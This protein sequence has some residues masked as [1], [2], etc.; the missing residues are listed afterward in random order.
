MGR[1][2]SRRRFWVMAAV[3]F[4]VLGSFASVMG[5]REAARNDVQASRQSLATTS[6]STAATLKLALLHEQDLV[7]ATGAF[8]VNS[9]GA[10]EGQFS[11]WMASVRALQ[12]YPELVGMAEVVIVPKSQLASFETKQTANHLGP[13]Q[14]TPA[15]SRPYYCFARVEI[16]RAGQMKEPAGLDFCDTPLGPLFLKAVDTGQG[17]ILPFRAGNTD[18]LAIG[19]PVYSS[20][21]A[22]ATPAARRADFLGWTGTEIV[23][24]VLLTSALRGHANTAV[25]FHYRSGSI[26]ASFEAGSA[27]RG[28]SSQSVNLHDGWNVKVYGTLSAGSIF[29]NAN[30]L[31]LLLGGIAVSLLIGALMYVLA[32]SRSRALVLVHQRTDELEHLALHDP[33]TG[34]PNRA[35]ILDR[36]TQMNARARRDRSAVALFYLDL[37]DFKDINDSLGHQLGDRLLIEVGLR[38]SKALREGDTVGRLGGDEFVVLVEGASLAPGAEAV[39][40]RILDVMKAPFFVGDGESPLNVSTSIGIAEGVRQEPEELLRDADIA[41][42]RAKRFGKRRAVVFLPSMQEDIVDSRALTVDL[43]GALERREL[44]LQYQPIV[45]LGSGKV[46]GVEA[47]VRWRHP[48]KGLL[49]PDTFIPAME[50]NGLIVPVG[51]WVLQEACRRGAQMLAEGFM[52][53]VSVNVSAKQLDRDRIIDDVQN[54]LSSSGFPAGMLTLELTE[55][56]LMVDVDETLERLKALKAL[57]VHLAIDDFGTG[58]SS[59]AYVRQFPI[60]VLKIDQSFVAGLGETAEAGALV[61]SLV[62]LGKALGIRTIAEGVETE[63]QRQTLLAE[64]TD[65]AQGFYFARPLDFSSVIQLL[66]SQDIGVEQRLLAR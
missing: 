9:P 32:T 10:N 4:V 62:E 45:N 17:A 20:G 54:A 48:T 41:M 34:L 22:P 47:L 12:R 18:E 64:N 5:A 13:F 51:L 57:G 60:D 66:R 27:P 30:S 65:E 50:S 7:V 15:G 58:Y 40:Q 36:I 42:Y 56:T 52:I 19:T 24:K 2:S 49:G 16:T 37:D 38:L 44:F 1:M 35:L 29:A 39:A 33:L 8:L 21:T 63:A 11:R 53:S 14:I 55:T 31:A 26:V 25:T 3:L 46:T 61:H 28:A 6:Q 43:Y 23:P 59:M